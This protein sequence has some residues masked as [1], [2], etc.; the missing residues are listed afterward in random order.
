MASLTVLFPGIGYT[1]DRPLL[2]YSGKMAAGAGYELIHIDFTG[3]KWSKEKI[4]DKAF[5]EET[6]KKCLQMTEEA[7]QNAGDLSDAEVIFIS[8]S[9]GTVVAT[10]YAKKKN[11]KVQCRQLEKIIFLKVLEIYWKKSTRR[12]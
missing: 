12:F 10:A 5:L 2:Y 7:L 8:K 11:L 6:M 4:K 3:L 9:I 1:C